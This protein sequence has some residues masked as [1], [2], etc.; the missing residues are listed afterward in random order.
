MFWLMQD[1][2]DLLSPP[3]DM[4][5]MAI[6]SVITKSNLNYNDLIGIMVVVFLYIYDIQSFHFNLK[7]NCT[8]VKSINHTTITN[9]IDRCILC[10]FPL[11][12]YP[13]TNWPFI[14][15]LLISR[16]CILTLLDCYQRYNKSELH[17]IDEI[18][19]SSLPFMFPRFWKCVIRH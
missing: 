7:H 8:Y 2:W 16:I 18:Y 17:V 11:N 5:A 3:C 15:Y 12:F 6:A 13:I 10:N 19:I 4:I 1:A 14:I 9:D